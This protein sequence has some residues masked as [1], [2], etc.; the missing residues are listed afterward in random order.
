MIG[1]A[2]P[3][4]MGRQPMVGALADQLTVMHST[5]Q[6][7]CNDCGQAG[8]PQGVAELSKV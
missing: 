3:V 7:L 5:A 6:Q 4:K 2:K 8:S 1:V